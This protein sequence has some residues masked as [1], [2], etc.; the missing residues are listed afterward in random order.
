MTFSYLEITSKIRRPIIPIIIKSS[1]TVILYSGL[2]DS[3]ADYCIF[4]L[5]IAKKLGLTLSKKDRIL[6]VGVGKKQVKGFWGEIEIR[7]SD[8][9]YV[10]KVI[11]AEIS[12][13]GHGILGQKGFFDHFD[14]ALSYQ[15]QSIDI[16]PLE[17]KKN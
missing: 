7:I 13:F 8:K 16:S 4:S 12:E 14:V 10:A 11:F 15:K 5:E 6:F 1:T 3:G 2:I 17:D 9:T